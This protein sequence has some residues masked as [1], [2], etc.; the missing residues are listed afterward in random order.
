MAEAAIVYINPTQVRFITANPI[1]SR[2]VIGEAQTLNVVE[3]PE[4][5]YKLIN[6]TQLEFTHK[7]A[8]LR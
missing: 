3:D 7:L 6:Q 8:I 1:G 5:I 4:T 2:I